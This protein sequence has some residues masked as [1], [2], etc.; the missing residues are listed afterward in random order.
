MI[1][2]AGIWVAP[3]NDEKLRGDYEAATVSVWSEYENLRVPC[4]G[5][6]RGP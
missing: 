5:T 4:I 2:A 1:S 6:L 3:C